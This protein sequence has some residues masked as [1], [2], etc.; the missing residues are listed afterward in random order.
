[1]TTQPEW[2]IVLDKIYKENIVWEPEIEIDKE[3]PVVKVVGMSAKSVQENLALLDQAG[4]IGQVHVGISAD[5]PR[6]DKEG[7]IGIPEE[8]RSRGTHIGLTERGF[9]VAHERQVMEKQQ[10]EQDR[11][12]GSQNEINS[13]IGFLTLGLLF[14]TFADTW[15]S[16]ALNAGIENW[17]LTVWLGLATQAIFILAIM[18]HQ[19]ELL[20]PHSIMRSD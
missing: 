16:A 11:L 1:M 2:A 19:T 13:A 3:H 8:A 20:N 6:P 12:I 10:E 14:L 17:S 15:T 18:L 5:I 9:S 4:L 7:L